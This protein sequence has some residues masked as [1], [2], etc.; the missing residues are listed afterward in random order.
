MPCSL[1]V[2]PIT[3]YHFPVFEPQ[4]Y[5]QPQIDIALPG[6]QTPGIYLALRMPPR[7]RH[8]RSRTVSLGAQDHIHY[9]FRA[10]LETSLEKPR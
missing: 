4:I 10:S 3:N 1:E 7:E 5:Y 9:K 2:G 6:R 8:V